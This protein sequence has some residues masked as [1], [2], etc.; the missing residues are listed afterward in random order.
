MV[1]LVTGM[2]GIK[3]IESLTKFSTEYTE[4]KAGGTHIDNAPI[5]IKLDSEIEKA[6]TENTSEPIIKRIWINKILLLPYSEFKNCWN[7]AVD[8]VIKTVK[9]IKAKGNNR[10]IFINLHSCYFHNRTQEYLSL[11]DLKKIKELDPQIV[12]TFIDDIFDIHQRLNELGGIY[13]DYATANQTQMILRYF[14]LLDWRSKETMMSKFVATQLEKPHYVLAVKHSYTTLFNL[15]FKEKQFKKA[16]LSHPITEVRRLEKENDP[17][18]QRIKNEIDQLENSLSKIFTTF[19]PTTIDEYRIYTEVKP[20]TNST[21]QE[22]IYFSI[23]TKR[24][25]EEKYAS[26]DDFLYRVSGFAGENSLW[27]KDKTQIEQDPEI[28]QLLSALSSR[29]SNQVTTR[30]YTLVEQSEVLIIYRPL[31]NGNAS[32]GVQEEFR[33]YNELEKKLCFILCPIDDT[34]KFYTKQL[35]YQIKYHVE[36]TKRLR[37]KNG[38]SFLEFDHEIW[39]DIDPAILDSKEKLSEFIEDKFDNKIEFAEFSEDRVPLG[40]DELSDFKISFAENLLNS[41]S[42][43][44]KYKE[45]SCTKIDEPLTIDQWVTTIYNFTNQKIVL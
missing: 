32:G 4:F 12:I 31:F 42:L 44:K 24:W 3:I 25:D 10:Y 30:D 14:S 20:K 27:I 36:Q 9:E 16:Y 26:Q 7:I 2:S 15:V 40:P 5:I 38:L 23:L 28:N 17:Q 22:K 6:Y 39:N 33:Y 11:L 8:R 1:V 19:S 35:N 21:K 29:I 41:F 45:K 43:L 34:N 18:T 37:I 13:H